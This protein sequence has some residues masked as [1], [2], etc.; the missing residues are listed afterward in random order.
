MLIALHASSKRLS[1]RRTLGSPCCE[2][3]AAA[4]IL[5]AAARQL[6][7]EGEITGPTYAI[8]EDD[9]LAVRELWR[10]AAAKESDEAAALAKLKLTLDDAVKERAEAVT[11][12][13]VFGR[14][15]VAGAAAWIELELI[16]G[17]R[18]HVE[19][20]SMSAAFVLDRAA[21]ALFRGQLEDDDRQRRSDAC[22]MGRYVTG[23]I[24]TK[25]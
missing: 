21:L 3:V 18:L 15:D 22:L 11:M 7:D 20:A 24:C 23:S 12:D 25:V 17:L 16:C 13:M 5:L 19:A 10:E 8:S 4:K 1:T 2:R 6:S 14:D 9:F